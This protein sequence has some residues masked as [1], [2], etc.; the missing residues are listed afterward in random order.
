MALDTGHPVQLRL[1]DL[2][3]AF[4]TAK[5]IVLLTYVHEIAEVQLDAK[6]QWLNEGGGEDNCSCSP[7]AL[8]CIVPRGLS[9][10]HPSSIAI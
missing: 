3:T 10:P 9:C 8:I 4:D 7:E 6:Q 5:P 1:P 2:T